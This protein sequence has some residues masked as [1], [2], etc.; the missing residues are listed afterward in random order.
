MTTLHQA[1]RRALLALLLVPAPAIAQDGDRGSAAVL[2]GVS[3]YDLSGT[4]TS[5]VVSLRGTTALERPL[6]LEGALAY[7][8]YTSQGSSRVHHVLPEVQAQLQWVRD[9]IRPYLGAGVGA[10]FAR[11]EADDFGD[12]G[13]TETDLTV[14]GAGGV[15]WPL[16][17]AWAIQGELR[18]RAIDPWTGTTADWGLGT[19]GR[20]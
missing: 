6:L 19:V 11:W 3:Q 8:P 12:G 13:R 7:L 4:G 10:S 15:R 2:G 16:G 14:S 17:P 1:I 18:I 9:G 20:F 5:A